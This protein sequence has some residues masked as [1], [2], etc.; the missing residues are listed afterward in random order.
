MDGDRPVAIHGPI[1]WGLETED[2]AM[3]CPTV[4][5]VADLDGDGKPEV[6]YED[7]DG[8]TIVKTL[9]DPPIER[10][11][12]QPRAGPAGEENDESPE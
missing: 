11:V 3:Q 2:V 1:L 4:I 9:A 10:G 5:D 8:A 6:I 12:V 7:A